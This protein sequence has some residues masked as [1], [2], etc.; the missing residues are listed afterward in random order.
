M[1]TFSNT[2]QQPRAI[3]DYGRVFVWINFVGT[4]FLI[5]IYFFALLNKPVN[6]DAGYTL[7]MV[8]RIVE[9]MTFGIDIR[10][11]HTSAVL[12]LLSFVRL[13]F[14]SVPP[15]PV[16]LGVVYLFFAGS[17]LFVYLIGL[18]I[19]KSRAIAYFVAMMFLI[20]AFIFEAI[21]M[22]YEAFV[23]FF[24]LAALYLFIHARHSAAKFFVIGTLCGLAYIAKQYGLA[25]S[26]GIGLALLLERDRAALPQ[27]ARIVA[28]MIAG[29]FL[30][31]ALYYGYFIVIE[32]IDLQSMIFLAFGG[33]YEKQPISLDEFLNERLHRVPQVYL[34][35]IFFFV[36]K[37]RRDRV[38]LAIV[39]T[40]L[41]ALLPNLVRPYKHYFL[42][43]LPYAM[44]MFL[45]CYLWL[46]RV[47]VSVPLIAFMSVFF[48]LPV[49]KHA[50][51]DGRWFTLNQFRQQQYEI[52]EEINEILPPRSRVFLLTSPAYA[53]VCNFLP[54]DDLAMGH[55]FLTLIENKTL[56]K[57][58]KTAPA[59]I[60]QRNSP[61]FT[62]I[63]EKLAKGGHNLSQAI[64]QS[65]YLHF[66]LPNS[67]F[68]IWKL[69][70]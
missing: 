51:I 52:G 6:S 33:W 5:T 59:V 62:M 46:A 25:T 23:V 37:W 32:G 12:Y 7:P 48:F 2:D 19:I 18:H 54:V 38:F 15:Y 47:L 64:L 21:L 65:H 11:S 41:I 55:N 68:E 35:P 4:L 39:I 42:Q 28:S 43:A 40:F 58:L 66:V 16:Y 3:T 67:T 36:K 69:R 31:L 20:A 56:L 63:D 34:I 70:P 22:E 50:Y 60:V 44:L 8:E 45:Y 13:F 9:G 1:N 24:S 27:L 26:G 29:F 53:Y 57:E 14:D 10:V 30:P 17:A 61:Y 49:A